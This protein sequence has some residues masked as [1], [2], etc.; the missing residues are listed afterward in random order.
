MPTLNEILAERGKSYGSYNDKTE[1]V[2]TVKDIMR[3]QPSWQHMHDG[4][5]EAL[6]MIATKIGRLLHGDPN[7]EDSWVD[8]AGYANLAAYGDIQ[9]RT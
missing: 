8:I 7:H 3:V 1:F 6:D 5:R 9:D 2:Q 4:G